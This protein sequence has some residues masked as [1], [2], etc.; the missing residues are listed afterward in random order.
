MAT[1]Y[2]SADP[3]RQYFDT[4]N[5]PLAGGKLYSYAA[6]TTTPLAVYT[7][8]FLTVPAT[9]PVTLD[10]YGRTLFYVTP[11]VAYKFT[12]T[13]AALVVQP[14]YPVD[15]VIMP[16]PT[17]VTPASVPTG[18]VLPYSGSA[19]PSADYLLCDG[20]EYPQSTYPAL[21]AVCSTTYNTGGE[22]PAYFRVPDLR[23]RVPMGK[24]VSGTGVALGEQ[25]GSIDH[26]HTVAAHHHTTGSHTHDTTITGANAGVGGSGVAATG[27]YTSSAQSA[28]NTGDTTLTTAANNQKY[29]VLNF[30]IK[31]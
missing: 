25:G 6:G 11:N 29:L 4:S 9:N 28:S 27:T 8:A 30:I 5:A 18:T 15:N 19:A 12:L 17:A 16:S 20:S 24:A 3:I 14:H 1:G 7:D 31:T 23:Q 2:I 22:T 13:D 26:T 21:F 10:A